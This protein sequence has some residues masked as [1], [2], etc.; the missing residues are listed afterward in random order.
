MLASFSTVIF[1]L[2]TLRLHTQYLPLAL[3]NYYCHTI[4]LENV[5]FIY[6]PYVCVWF[7]Y[8]PGCDWCIVNLLCGTGADRKGTISM[9]YFR[10]SQKMCGGDWRRNAVDTYDVGHLTPTNILLYIQR[11]LASQINMKNNIFYK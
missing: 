10:I 3:M 7:V 1:Y 5:L 9:S 8:T 4:N 11:I 6:S 2:D